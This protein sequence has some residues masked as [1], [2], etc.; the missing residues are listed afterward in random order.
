MSRRGA[1]VA[2]LRAAARVSVATAA[3]ASTSDGNSEGDASSAAAPSGD[4]ESSSDKQEKRAKSSSSSSSGSATGNAAAS[5]KSQGR[6]SQAGRQSKPGR[7]SLSAFEADSEDSKEDLREF[8]ECNDADHL[9]D[10]MVESMGVSNPSDIS[11]KITVTDLIRQGMD[12]DEAEDLLLEA[13]GSD[14]A[15]SKASD[16]DQEVYTEEQLKPAGDCIE[17]LRLPRSIREEYIFMETLHRPCQGR[18]VFLCEDISG[19]GT[20]AQLRE[21][22][23]RE[24]STPRPAEEDEHVSR[25]RVGFFLQ[26]VTLATHGKTD[27]HGQVKEQ[28]KDGQ[29]TIQSQRRRC[30]LKVW[31]KGARSDA[32]T[33]SWLK[34]Q[35]KLL[36]MERHPNVCLPRRIIEDHR[37]YY[38]EF[39]L[40]LTGCCLLQMILNDASTTERQVKRII[41]GVLRGLAHLHKNGFVHRDVKPDNVLV[42]MRNLESKLARGAIPPT[43]WNSAKNGVKSWQPVSYFKDAWCRHDVDLFVRVVDLDTACEIKLGK[44]GTVVPLRCGTPGYMAPEAYVGFGG[45]EADLWGV[46]ILLYLM[47]RCDS[48]FNDITFAAMRGTELTDKAPFGIMEEVST[49]IKKRVS[50][51]DWDEQPWNQ[52]PLCRDICRML[53]HQNPTV[54]GS[55][56]SDVLAINPWFHK[57]GTGIAN[58]QLAHLRPQGIN[59]IEVADDDESDEGSEEVELP[60]K[61]NRGTG[62][63]R[64]G[65]IQMGGLPG[66]S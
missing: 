59:A 3:L 25:K 10:W 13:G 6:K 4:D 18:C 43:A 35:L 29:E 47:V 61:E 54:R 46:G 65:N 53:L 34:S 36:M 11:R 21:S 2:D 33:K 49:A 1:N 32:E 57:T 62:A 60:Q 44:K 14:E 15:G 51:I 64:R 23:T 42:E 45:V 17:Q 9:F 20:S 40:V 37:A 8:L 56:A 52:L 28:R 66:L 38:I 58:Q 16:S 12:E 48:P 41:R 31:R 30:I 7:V 55:D 63:G 39:D 22:E 27:T 26:D 5:R 50:E 24:T 19:R